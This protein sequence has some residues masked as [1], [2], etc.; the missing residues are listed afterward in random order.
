MTKVS[1][2][3]QPRFPPKRSVSFG[4]LALILFSCSAASAQIPFY[5]DDADTTDKGKF[6]FEF[7]NEHDVLQRELYPAKR[8]NT[9]N[10][11]L[12]YGVTKRIEFGI[13]APLLTI[14]DAKVSGIRGVTGNGDTQ[15]GVKYR[16]HD[17]HEDS[18][19]PALAAVF[20][21]EF[22]T[23]STTKQLGSGLIDYWLYGVAQ[24]SLTKKTT[25]RLNG[26][27]L[28][29]GNESTGLIGIST[30]RGRVF[31]GSGSITKDFTPKF[32]LGAELFGAVT[33]NF[34][35]SKGQLA[36]QIGGNYV[37]SK[38]FTL[39]FGV[40]GGRFVASPR[41]GGLIGFAYD[42]K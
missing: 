33:G 6:H 12:D 20:Y 3:P 29:A 40:T 4:L 31:T 25:F 21:V 15:L 5:T 32:R 9:A 26:G 34:Q 41:L 10:F 36:T 13:N 16:F 2:Y 35:L 11:T 1:D 39:A 37:L 42:F 27:I 14:S 18:K 38:R 19:L 28:F 23:G 30:T 17:E 24:K 7:F 22:P 8:Q